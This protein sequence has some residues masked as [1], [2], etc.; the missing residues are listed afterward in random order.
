MQIS[1]LHFSKQF[2]RQANIRAIARGERSFSKR[3][4]P[5]RFVMHTRLIPR[6]ITSRTNTNTVRYKSI[7]DC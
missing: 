7:R 1:H 6:V 2:L 4:S 5:A 3:N